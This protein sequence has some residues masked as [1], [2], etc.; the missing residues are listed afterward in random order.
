MDNDKF[1]FITEMQGWLNIIKNIYNSLHEQSKGKKIILSQLSYQKADIETEIGVSNVYSKS[2]PA[3]GREEKQDWEWKEVELQCRPN[4][5]LV[6]QQET[7]SELSHIR[8]GS[9]P[10][11][12]TLL[13]HWIQAALGKV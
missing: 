7:P 9:G 12:L 10:L 11:S 1:E 2:I 6:V 4:K 13:S 8:Q 3:K 5:T